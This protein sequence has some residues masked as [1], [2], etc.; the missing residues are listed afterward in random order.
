MTEDKFRVEVVGDLTEE[1]AEKF[2]YGDGVAGGW[3]GIVNDSFT[4]K[5]ELV[6]AKNQWPE[7]YQRCGG[8]IG[9]LQQCVDARELKGTWA[10]ALKNVVVGPRRAV[11]RGF[12]PEIYIVKGGEAPLWTDV[13]WR[14]VLERITTAPHHAV[15]ASE[16][17]IELGEGGEDVLLSMVKYN[18]LALRPPSTLARDLPQEVYGVG[19]DDVVNSCLGNFKQI[20]IVEKISTMDFFV[21]FFFVVGAKAW[22][23]FLNMPSTLVFGWFLP[24]S[25]LS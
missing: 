11:L 8:N 15:L 18:L 22:M 14:M 16:I 13:Q 17:E 3:R 4:T 9:L 24:F 1:E 5:E 12:E 20:Q 19:N 6:E 25:L 2:M 7:I 23:F 10:S 21:D